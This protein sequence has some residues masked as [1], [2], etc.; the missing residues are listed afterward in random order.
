MVASLGARHIVQLF[1]SVPPLSSLSLRPLQLIRPLVEFNPVRSIGLIHLSR[2][3][4]IAP[5]PPM[6]TSHVI[7]TV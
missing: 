4:I 1:S 6:I 7:G 2:P 3:G 5:F